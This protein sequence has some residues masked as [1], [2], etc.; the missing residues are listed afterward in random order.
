MKLRINE[1][2]YRN[3]GIPYNIKKDLEKQGY[4]MSVFGICNYAD[5][6]DTV[7]LYDIVTNEKAKYVKDKN[8]FGKDVIKYK[9]GYISE[10]GKSD[11]PVFSSFPNGIVARII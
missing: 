8:D 2:D 1:H 9:S 6:G 4:D 10:L 3:N 11:R 7:E 5:Y